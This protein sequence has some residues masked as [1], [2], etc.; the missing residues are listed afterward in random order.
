[1]TIRPLWLQ[2]IEQAW[3]KR[4]I[5]WL[6][7]VRR[8]GKTTISR[9][10]ENSHYFNCDLPSVVRR[11][12]DPE[13]FFEPFEEKAIL[14]FDEIHRVADPSGL[15]KIAADEHPHLRVLATGS[16]TLA[17]TKKFRD[18]L[19]GR[20][21]LLYL[22]PVL[23][24][25]CMDVFSIKDL[26]HRLLQ[27]GLPEALLSEQNDPSFYSEWIDSF[28]ARDIQELFN[29]R[30]RGAF[31]KL[32]RLLLCQSGG[33]IDYTNLA[34][35]SDL[36]RPT[37]QVH[38][39]AMRIA[40]AIFLLSPFHGGARREITQRPKCY[41]FD[42]GFVAFTNGWEILRDTDRGPLWEHLVLD[43]LRTFFIPSQIF[44][45]RDKSGHEIDF[46]LKDKGGRVH[47]VE[48]KVNA[49]HFDAK[50]LQYFRSHYPEGDN[51]VIT[52]FL[53][54][55]YSLTHGIV[56]VNY[57]SPSNCLLFESSVNI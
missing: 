13:S 42:T 33:L 47:A 34:K 57:C 20:K 30:N 15:L 16:S 3:K 55:S 36:S 40:H 29:I 19:T 4:S 10:I 48:C 17:A 23:W 53:K 27:G 44:Y 21:H 26:D 45:W 32:L 35:L 56:K 54:E 52:P 28:Y 41:A 9:M 50:T 18:S 14:I 22:P 24:Q 31:L 11:L 46:V 25:E 43:T 8:V 37:V 6:S 49:S 12:T 51:Y 2:R 39:E 1:M 7:G 38:L 5:T